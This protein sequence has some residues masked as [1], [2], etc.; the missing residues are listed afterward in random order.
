MNEVLFLILDDLIMLSLVCLRIFFSLK[1]NLMRFNCSQELLF[2]L[3]V[4]IID[5]HYYQ[6]FRND[7]GILW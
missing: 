3:L 5:T 1:K 4:S 7:D 6:S 2:A